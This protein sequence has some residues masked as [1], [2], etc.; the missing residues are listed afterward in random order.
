MSDSL[1]VQNVSQILASLALSA[2]LQQHFML[3]KQLEHPWILVS[4]G[5][6]GT[7]SPQILILNVNI[8]LSQAR[9]LTS[10]IPVLWEGEAG[11]SFETSLGN[12]ARPHL[13]KKLK[14]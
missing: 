7:N 5:G 3:Y 9:W 10:V 13:Y 1:K 4:S 11:K 12:T 14:N 2:A 8:F 6:P